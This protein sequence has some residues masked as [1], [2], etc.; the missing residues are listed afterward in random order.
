MSTVMKFDET[1]DV[2]QNIVILYRGMNRQLYIG[3]VFY[4]NGRG[5]G[6]DWMGV[7]YEDPLPEE[8]G[9]IMGWNWLDDNSPRVVLVPVPDATVGVEDFLC[10]HNLEKNW[11]SIDYHVVKSFAEMEDYV[12]KNPIP[13]GQ[14]VAFGIRK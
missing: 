3:S 5:R 12:K 6:D 4:Y 11:K 7:F 8:N 10:V 2:F 9:L 14:A 1:I 13:E